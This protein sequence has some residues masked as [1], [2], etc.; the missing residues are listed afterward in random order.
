M[1][2]QFCRVG[3]ITPVYEKEIELNEA[4]KTHATDYN[5]DS[6]NGKINEVLE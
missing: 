3:K 5:E 1:N 6:D 4:L 2:T